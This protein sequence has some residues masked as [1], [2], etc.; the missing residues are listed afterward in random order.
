MELT[1]LIAA[2]NEGSVVKQ[3]T[4]QRKLTGKAAQQLIRGPLGRS[5]IVSLGILDLSR[6]CL[7]NL[8]VGK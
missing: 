5:K 4:F 1:G 3:S 7:N 6:F 8:G 2:Q